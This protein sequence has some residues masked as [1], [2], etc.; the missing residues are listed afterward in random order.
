MITFGTRVFENVKDKEIVHF[1][2]FKIRGLCVADTVLLYGSGS[3]D[4][5]VGDTCLI[6]AAGRLVRLRRL[7]CVK[8][9]LLGLRGKV[10]V[11]AVS[12]EL[13][14]FKKAVVGSLRAETAV[15]GQ[16]TLVGSVESRRAVFLDPH[17]WFKN[18]PSINVVE[19]RYSVTG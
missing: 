6:L 11:D 8:A 12:A 3:G 13:A 16:E 4:W 18:E 19:Y 1:G 2:K 10:V 5:V 15:F 17:V 7:D 14:F 9:F